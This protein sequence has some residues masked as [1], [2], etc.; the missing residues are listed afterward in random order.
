MMFV[1][2][3][4]KIKTDEVEGQNIDLY[5]AD[6]IILSLQT[7]HCASDMCCIKTDTSFTF[8]QTHLQLGSGNLETNFC[9]DPFY[10]EIEIFGTD[11]II[12]FCHIKNIFA[13][14]RHHILI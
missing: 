3:F 13:L 6:I 12:H 7:I 9:T 4:E 1:S 2:F 10:I 14:V 8:N 11:F 5:K